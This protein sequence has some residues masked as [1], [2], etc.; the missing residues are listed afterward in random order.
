MA[1]SIC[2]RPTALSP[3]W[4]GSMPKLRNGV[5]SP[6]IAMDF[7]TSPPEIFCC[8]EPELSLHAGLYRLT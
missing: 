5:A 8:S 1:L 3:H 6:Y 2:S 4:H 7:T